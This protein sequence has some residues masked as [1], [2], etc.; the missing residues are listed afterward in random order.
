MQKSDTQCVKSKDLDL[1][2]YKEHEYCLLCGRR[3]K[4]PEARSI[5]YGATCLKKHA[6]KSAKSLF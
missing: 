6:T 3:L 5:G 1:S 2:T 4:K